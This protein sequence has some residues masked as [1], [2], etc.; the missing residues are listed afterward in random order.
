LQQ[1]F[2]ASKLNVNLSLEIFGNF[3]G[4]PSLKPTKNVTPKYIKT[5]SLTINS[6]NVKSLNCQKAL[7]FNVREP[8]QGP[9]IGKIRDSSW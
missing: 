9:P 3:Q 2:A 8:Q 5:K 1:F 6:A 4:E 7:A